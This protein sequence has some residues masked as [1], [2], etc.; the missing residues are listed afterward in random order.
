[1]TDKEGSVEWLCHG[2]EQYRSKKDGNGNAI[3]DLGDEG[4]LGQGYSATKFIT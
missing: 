3:E 4:K 1:M 2:I